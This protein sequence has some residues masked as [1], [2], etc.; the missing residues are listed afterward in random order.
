ME[1]IMT[2]SEQTFPTMARPKVAISIFGNLPLDAKG[3]VNYEFPF[4]EI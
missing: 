3:T 1:I 2:N 4:L